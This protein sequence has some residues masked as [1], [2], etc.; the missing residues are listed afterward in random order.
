[1]AEPNYYETLGVSQDASAD[2]IK[3]AYRKLVRKYHPD[4]SKE[5]DADEKT[6]AI[7]RAY[8]T[9]KNTE[10][11]AEY[12]AMLANPYGQGQH[13][14]QSQEHSG[15]HYAKGHFGDGEP[16]GQ[17]DFRFDDI[18][19][20]FG[21]RQA[22]GASND[23]GQDQHAELTIDIDAAYVGATRALTINMPSI[24]ADGQVAFDEKTLNVKI[25]KGISEGQ[26]I[27]LT[28]Q[29]LPG[30]HGAK[31]GDLY[32][33]IRFKNTEKLYVKRQK[34][35]YQ[36]V[37]ITPWEAALGGRINVN[38]PAG[39]LAISIPPNSQHGKTLRLKG[40][41]IPAKVAGDLYIVLSLLMPPV[42]STKDEAIW[43][44]L[45]EHYQ[46]FTP[47]R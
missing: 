45:A 46:Q 14:Y 17:G 19:S 12:D 31:A 8:D 36:T 15:Y 6:A 30:F 23:S 40:K 20:A 5:P 11:R 10:K 39:Q 35:V 32:L 25:P 44:A 18:F 27:R 28:G 22:R 37:E 41:G 43:Q 21:Q 3:K 7:N 26:S 13:D 42:D 47:Q 33:S 1:M 9:L 4:V 38:T 16:F 34:D 24:T 2:D 29:G